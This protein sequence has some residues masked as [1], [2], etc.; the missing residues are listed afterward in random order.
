MS[1]FIKH[2][3]QSQ[4]NTNTQVSIFF[5][6]TRNQ[7][8]CRETYYFWSDVVFHVLSEQVSLMLSFY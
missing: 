3:K 1:L 6:W 4:N 5:S 7:Q 8:Y 2:H